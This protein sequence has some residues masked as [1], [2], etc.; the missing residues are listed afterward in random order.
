MVPDVRNF[1]MYN[2]LY[3]DKKK[4]Q[5]YSFLLNLH[6]LEILCIGRPEGW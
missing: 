2:N 5:L 4:K 6:F 3:F 1:K